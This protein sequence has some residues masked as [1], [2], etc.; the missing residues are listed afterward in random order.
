MAAPSRGAAITQDGANHR[1]AATHS[2]IP[3]LEHSAR[4]VLEDPGVQHVHAERRLAMAAAA[5]ARSRAR[6]RLVCISFVSFVSWVR[7]SAVTRLIT[8]RSGATC[9]AGKPPRV[10]P[11]F[12]PSDTGAHQAKATVRA[13]RVISSTTFAAPTIFAPGARSPSPMLRGFV[14]APQSHTSPPFAMNSG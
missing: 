11:A 7:Y 9:V 3:V 4:I 12:G 5:P 6:I 14:H 1:L 10:L 13:P 2:R 8:A